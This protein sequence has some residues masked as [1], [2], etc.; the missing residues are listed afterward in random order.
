MN[1]SRPVLTSDQ[2][3]AVGTFPLFDPLVPSATK[4]APQRA[5]TWRAAMEDNRDPANPD[6]DRLPLEAWLIILLVLAAIAG[7]IFA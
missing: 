5:R 2:P 7:A 6:P 3:T 4:N 1:R